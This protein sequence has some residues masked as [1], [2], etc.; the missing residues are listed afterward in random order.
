MSRVAKNPIVL[1]EG[2]TLEVVNSR[3]KVS[4]P[5]G[6]DEFQLP[7]TIDLVQG[8]DK[9]YTIKYDESSSDS[10]ALAGTSRSI[11]HNM[12]IGVTKGFEKKL[13]LVGV[14]YRAKVS[15][16]LVELTLGFSHP[17]KHELPEEVTA[18]TPSQTEIVLRSHNKQIL[19][20]VASEI[21]AYRPP[22]PYKGKGVRYAD[23]QIKRKEAKKAAGAGVGA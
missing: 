8:D 23:E 22:E 3:V 9:T 6:S 21:R 19:G 16:K 1:S 15:G 14:G 5:Q 7:L 12:I 13:E 11:I 10:T 20:Q 2:A 4:G 18:E 17:I